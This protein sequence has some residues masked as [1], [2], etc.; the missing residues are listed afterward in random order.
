MFVASYDGM[1]IM[2]ASGGRLLLAALLIAGCGSSRLASADGTGA[3]GQSGFGDAGR[4]ASCPAASASKARPASD[5]GPASPEGI[6][7]QYLAVLDQLFGQYLRG[8]VQV[9]RGTVQGQATTFTAAGYDQQPN[10]TIAQG[11]ALAS[12]AFRPGSVEDWRPI[13]PAAFVT[14]NQAILVVHSLADDQYMVFGQPQSDPTM[15]ATSGIETAPTQNFLMATCN[16]CAPSLWAR[17]AELTFNLAASGTVT[18]VTY[19]GDATTSVGE[20]VNSA[21]SVQLAVVP[22]CDLT[23]DD[24]ATLN[25]TTGPNE[26]GQVSLASFVV[27]GSERI[28]HTGGAVTIKPASNGQCDGQMF[29]YTIDVYVSSANL[30]DYGV[31]NY[32]QG[33]TQ[34][35]CGV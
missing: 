13:A 26:L 33:P 34:S 4:D 27:S 15:T 16:G 3:A 19:A 30:G 28:W 10:G 31:R 23:F 14:G 5:A 32:I 25:E 11:A 24:L 12:L 20:P 18:T 35:T 9:Y 7:A 8:D 29:Q 17:P 22:P 2:T 1:R 6:E 21:A